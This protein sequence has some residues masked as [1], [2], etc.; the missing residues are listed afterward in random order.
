MKSA[1]RLQQLI[2]KLQVMM[3]MM[4]SVVTG[5]GK[6]SKKEVDRVPDQKGAEL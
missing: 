1:L 5:E 4:M 3:M 2:M 6:E